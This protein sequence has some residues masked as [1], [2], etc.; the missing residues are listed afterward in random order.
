[1][2]AAEEQAAELDALE[3]IFMG[4][5]SLSAPASAARGAAFSVALAPDAAPDLRLRLD[6]EHPPRYPDAV[7]VVT[8]HALAGLSAPRRKAVQAAAEKCAAE[9]VG[10][11]SVF[12]VC[13]GVKEW[14]EM[15]IGEG[16][17]EEDVQVDDG[18][19]FE[20]RDVTLAA[21]VEVIASK[22]IGTPVTPE[23]FAEWRER[24]MAEVE[25]AKTAEERRREADP[26]PT[27]R[28]LFERSKAAVVSGESESFWEQ[29]AE[30][31]FGDGEDEASAA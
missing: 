5:Y 26:R 9:N 18:G 16:E 31:A 15:N 21:K 22:A 13:E 14:V 7:L 19:L 11:P 27:G 29:E 23:T 25:Q 1:M 24:F 30:V 8:V 10:M 3:A 12:S 28:E 17:E 6:F 20:T 2:D 4:E